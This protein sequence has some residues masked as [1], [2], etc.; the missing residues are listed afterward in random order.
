MYVG[1]RLLPHIRVTTVTDV[2]KEI[3]GVPAVLVLDQD[4]DGG[5]LS[6]Q[7]IDFLAEDEGATSGTWAPTRRCTRAD[8]S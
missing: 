1:D 8:S 2:T 3:D 6:E 7:S 5:Q 4:F